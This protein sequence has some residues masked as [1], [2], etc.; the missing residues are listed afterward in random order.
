MQAVRGTQD[1]A[2]VYYCATFSCRTL[3]TT[4][5]QAAVEFRSKLAAVARLN[6]E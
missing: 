1:A 6:G 4:L 3:L 2:L 5:S